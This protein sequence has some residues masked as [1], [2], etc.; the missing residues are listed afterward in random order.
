MRSGHLAASSVLLPGHNA[1]PPGVSSTTFSAQLPNLQ[2]HPLMTVDFAII[3]LLVRIR[4]PCIRFLCV[5]SQIRST[6]LSDLVSRLR[7]C[8][9]LHFIV[10][11]LCKDLHLQLL[12]MPGTPKRQAD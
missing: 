4:L 12:N 11:R 6:L 9:S 7:P 5:G 8:A 1:E 3:G 10:I 2:P